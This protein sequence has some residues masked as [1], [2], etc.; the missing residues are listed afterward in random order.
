MV[1]SPGIVKLP[2]DAFRAVCNSA[3]CTT[4]CVSAAYTIIFVF[5]PCICPR[6]ARAA[7]PSTISG[8]PNSP[9]IIYALF[10][11]KAFPKPACPMDRTCV[12]APSL[13]TATETI[14]KVVQA[15]GL[16]R[17]FQRLS[18]KKESS[19][20]GVGRKRHHYSA[21]R[22]SLPSITIESRPYKADV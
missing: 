22:H 2:S 13:S 11:P 3:H 20:Q 4:V 8:R 21:R 1:S 10:S 12:G 6:R 17:I 7:S 18:R 5:F 15:G 19:N 9:F 16:A 14:T